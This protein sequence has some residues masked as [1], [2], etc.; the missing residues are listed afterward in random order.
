MSTKIPVAVLAATGS[1]GQRFVQLLDRHPLFE[2]V[3]LT[4]SDRTTGQKYG[5]ACHWIL[6]GDMP[7]W[8]AEM[9]LLPT[10]AA[11][12]ATP[13]AFSAL[14]AEAALEIEPEF[15][16]AGTLVCSN[17]SAY[18]NEP[19]VPI[20]L[21][22]V[23]PDQAAILEAQRRRR[24]WTG[25]IVTNSNCTSTGMTVALKALQDAFG[26]RRVFAVSMQALSGAGYPGVSALDIVDNVI[27]WIRG[28]EEKVEWEPRKMLGSLRGEEIVPADFRISAH[29]NRVAVVDGHM[30]CLSIELANPATPEEA[31]RVLAEYQAPEAARDLPSAPRPVIVVRR[32][33]DRPQPRL[34]RMTGNGMATVVG[35]VRPDPLFDIKMVVFSHNTIRGAAGGSIYNAELLA[36][37]KVIGR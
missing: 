11:S 13:L 8:A 22:E 1:V 4:A 31:A 10:E 19:D 17:A 23:N 5:Q 14:P 24:G 26:L 3:A 21:P 28:E 20:L 34:D 12:A 25:G 33:P 15:A 37:L 9:T 16:R 35:R 32:E 29:T 6:P 36:R 30:V 2:V 7:G 18:R 27:P